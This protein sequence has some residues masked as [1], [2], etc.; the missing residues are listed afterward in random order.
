MATKSLDLPISAQ[1][2]ILLVDDDAV[3]RDEFKDCFEEYGIT[4]AANGEE[5][6]ALLNKPNE[7]DL[8][9]LDVR[10]YGLSGIDVLNK[11]RKINP[12]LRVVILTGYS[13]KDV[14]IDALRAQ[15]DDYIEK[16]LDIEATRRAIEKFLVSSH[17]EEGA[18]A[19]DIDK[20]IERVKSYIER[21]VSKKVTLEDAAATVYLSPKY[22]SRAFKEH[23]GVGFNDY[24]LSLKMQEAKKLLTATSYTVDQ[25]TDRLG[26]E[27]AESFIRQ[28]KKHTRKTPGAF[29]KASKNGKA[30]KR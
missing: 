24:K 2:K 3:F 11:I 30:K 5:A 14:A 17:R 19:V 7:I 15:A 25:I 12:N 20:K 18:D 27:T 23:A 4:E 22:L 29:R 28:F 8:V 21:N 1:K 26:Y 16:P 13:S 6:L 10:M 9:F